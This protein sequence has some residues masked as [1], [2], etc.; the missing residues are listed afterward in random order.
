MDIQNDGIVLIAGPSASPINITSLSV[1]TDAAT[2][3][4]DPSIYSATTC[5]Q[6]HRV[7][8]PTTFDALSGQILDVGDG[9]TPLSFTFPTPLQYKPPANTK[10]CLM[11]PPTRRRQTR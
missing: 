11:G 10:A 3:S 7:A 9:A 8:A 6:R 5:R 2:G 4:G 1:S